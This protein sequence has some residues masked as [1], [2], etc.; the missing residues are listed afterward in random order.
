MVAGRIADKQLD[1]GTRGQT[2]TKKAPWSTYEKKQVDY[3]LNKHSNADMRVEAL[4]EALRVP[5]ERWQSSLSDDVFGRVAEAITLAARERAAAPGLEPRSGPREG[6][7]KYRPD[8]PR[9][10]PA[11]AAKR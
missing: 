2:R 8:Q 4:M 10:Q 11:R 3:A 1:E 9:N 6:T 5:A 7:H